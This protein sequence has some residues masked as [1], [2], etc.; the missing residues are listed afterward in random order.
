MTNWIEPPPQQPRRM[1]CLGKGCLVLS[2][3]IVFLLIACAI[4]IY[5]GVKTHSAV[6]HAVVWAQRAGVLAQEPS[7]VPQFE[8]TEE[9][10]QAA[11]TKWDAFGTATG[12]NQPAQ[13]ELTADDLNNLIARNQRAR[14][15][16]FVSIEN[17][18]LR[19]RTSMP[20]G[21]Y[22]GRGAYYLNG[23]I[24]VQ[25]EGPRS[26]DHPPL[27]SISINGRTL[28]RDLLGWT[29]RSRPLSDYVAEYKEDL[30]ANTFEIRD[31]KL[32]LNKDSS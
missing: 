6:L 27:N 24:V 4:G 30:N 11:K 2:C 13:V 7:P 19:V 14:G 17:N 21:E 20:V 9:R 28:P 18:R 23:D 31:G 16:V 3:L 12:R 5:Y 15:K 10:M 29:Y 8:T 25:G 22:I 32:I 1:G 26:L